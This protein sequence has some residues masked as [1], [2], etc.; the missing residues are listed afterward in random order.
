MAIITSVANIH[1]CVT[2]MRAALS[3]CC[4]MWMEATTE[5]PPPIISPNPVATMS[6]GTQM[7]IAAIPSAPTA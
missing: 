6:I 7:F 3:F 2:L 1:A 5:Q 4:A